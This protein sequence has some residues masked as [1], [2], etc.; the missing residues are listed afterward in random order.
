MIR[1]VQISA[2]R[3]PVEVRRF[4]EDLRPVIEGLLKARGLAVVATEVEDASARLWVDGEADLADLIGTH[5]LVDPSRGQGARRRWFAGVSVRLV[6]ARAPRLD[7]RDVRFSADRAGG[8]GGQHVN[9][10]SS[11]VRALHV[12]TGLAV[13]VAEERSQHQNR[14]VALERLA[15]ALDARAREAEARTRAGDRAAHDAVVRGA[16][17][18]TWVREGSSLRVR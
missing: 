15:E 18:L 6:A 16:P 1:V 4:V 3:G 14:R 17:K 13:R 7:L 12:P 8:P 2:G 11:A 10:T 5:A 9:T